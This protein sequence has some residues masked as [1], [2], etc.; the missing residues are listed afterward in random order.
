MSSEDLNYNQNLKSRE[1]NYFTQEISF[2]EIL[3]NIIKFCKYIVSKWKIILVAAL[4]GGVAGY[5]RANRQSLFYIASSTF[6]LDDGSVNANVPSGFASFMGLDL[7][8]GGGIFQGDNLLELYRSRFM[9]KKVLLSKIPDTKNEY[10]ID[11]YIKINGF[12]QA[13]KD[14]AKLRNINFFIKPNKAYLRIQDSLM[15]IFVNDIRNNYL[16]VDRDR[17]VSILRV[18][19][20]SRDEEFSKLLNDQVV[21]TVNDFY[22]QTKTQKSL[23]YLKL[24]QHQADSIRAALN[25]NMFKVATNT[26]VNINVNPARQILRLPSQKSQI[27]AET[28]RAMLNDLVRNIEVSRMALKKETPLIQQLDEATFP[29]ERRRDSRAKAIMLGALIVALIVVGCYS[30]TFLFKKILE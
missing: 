29:L 18:E 16:I 20:R 13:W 5:I 19:T 15:T 27:D 23:E 6:I 11:R 9:L 7:P 4:I 2:K 24:L 12:K 21:K 26:D 3:L 25:G 28:N 8:S 30:V 10:L 17:R 14:S 1:E 22:I